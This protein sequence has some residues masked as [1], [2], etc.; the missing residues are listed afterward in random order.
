MSA[1]ERGFF[2][3]KIR[4]IRAIRGFSKRTRMSAEERGFFNDKIRVIRAIRGF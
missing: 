2:N 4:V 3:D 1:E